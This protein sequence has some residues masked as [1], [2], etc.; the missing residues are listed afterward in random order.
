MFRVKRMHLS[1]F[2]TV[3]DM[4]GD[5]ADEEASQH[6]SAQ[7]M[8]GIWRS[9]DQV[10]Y[11][12]DSISP[13]NISAP[14]DRVARVYGETPPQMQQDPPSAVNIKTSGKSVLDELDLRDDLSDAELRRIRRD[15]AVRNHPDRV[16]LWQRDEATQRMTLANVLID[17]ALKRKTARGQ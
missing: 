11:A 5:D 16:P 14:L 8:N 1:N 4:L 2:R 7:A 3:L 15:F 12:F 13:E 17:R 10:Q 9:S 6:T